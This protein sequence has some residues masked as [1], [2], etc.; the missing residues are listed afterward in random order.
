M[1]S[2]TSDVKTAETQDVSQIP[3]TKEVNQ[4]DNT[5]ARND[6]LEHG[7]KYETE[8]EGDTTVVETATDLVTKVIHVE[9]DPNM[10]VVTFRVVF[11][12]WFDHK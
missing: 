12:G 1:A 9:D 3:E 11:L 8:E 5:F 6:D 7:V 10:P 4:K 2:N